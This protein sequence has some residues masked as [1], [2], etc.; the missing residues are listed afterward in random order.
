MYDTTRTCHGLHETNG[1]MVP[2]VPR[3]VVKQK[4]CADSIFTLLVQH[5][6]LS[7]R[8]K[9]G[10]H[11]KKSQAIPHGKVA[12][13]CWSDAKIDR[14]NAQI[15]ALGRSSGHSEKVAE[16]SSRHENLS[17]GRVRVC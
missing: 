4:I 2:I 9:S 11:K 13:D 6:I 3:K 8:Y 10:G 16:A 7:R 14:F 1:A 15:V 5:P 12:L 17:Y